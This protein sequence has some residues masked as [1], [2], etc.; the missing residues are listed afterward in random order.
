MH[1]GLCAA[2]LDGE[3]GGN[4]NLGRRCDVGELRVHLRAQK[5]G[6][7]RIDRRPGARVLGK[8]GI[9]HAH[10]DALLGRGEIAPFNARVEAAV[11]AKHVVDYQKDQIR[12][13]NDQA[14]AA[15]G[16]GVNQVEIRRHDEVTHEL[17]VLLHLDGTDRNLDVAVHVVEQADAQEAGESLVDELHGGHAPAYDAFLRRQVVG[18]HAPLV[19]IVGF[20]FFG[21]PG[22]AAQQR[23]DFILGEKIR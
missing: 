22:N 9:E 19:A 17:A 18:A 6:L 1:F 5:L 16:L 20:R 12:I 11:A 15:Q 10:D 3:Y 21:F 14:D 4:D 13:E 2:Q 23:V 7:E 8:Y